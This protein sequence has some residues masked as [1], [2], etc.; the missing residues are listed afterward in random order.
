M[1]RLYARQLRLPSFHRYEEVVRQMKPEEGYEAFLVKIMKQEAEDRFMTGQ[2]RR[3]KAAGFPLFKTMDEFDCSRLAHVSEA[4]VRQLAAC[5][6]IKARQN[7]VMI[8]D[9]GSGKTH[10]AIALGMNACNAGF[11]VRFCTA[12]NLAAELAEAVQNHRLTRLEK[13]LRKTDLLIIDELSYLTFNRSQS[14]MLFQVISERS[15]RASVIITTN[16]AFSDWTQLFENEM[17]LSALID[18]VTFHSH[19]LDMNHGEG[20]VSYRL[21]SSMKS[22]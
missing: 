1:I 21:A 2:K 10:L 11:H 22:L 4:T 14:E 6:F 18:R 7:I 9:P 17:L 20:E 8:G 12:V 5:D 13:S 16:L 19:I 3:L 15:E